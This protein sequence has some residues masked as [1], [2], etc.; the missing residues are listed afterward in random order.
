[1]QR[2]FFNSAMQPEG[3]MGMQIC[4]CPIADS[5]IKLLSSAAAVPIQAQ[6]DLSLIILNVKP[7]GKGRP[8]LAKQQRRLGRKYFW[9]SQPQRGKQSP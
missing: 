4:A 8:R 2:S 6:R 3:Q 5:N 1:M 9:T 7:L